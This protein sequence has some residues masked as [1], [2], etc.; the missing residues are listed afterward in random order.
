MGSE[1]GG[2][3]PAKGG[4]QIPPGKRAKGLRKPPVVSIYDV[5][6]AF[7]R[8]GEEKEIL[9]KKRTSGGR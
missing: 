3:A 2:K 4:K 8:E 7:G 6:K 5:G 1:G 9:E